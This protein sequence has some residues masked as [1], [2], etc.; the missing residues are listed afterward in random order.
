MLQFPHGTCSL[1]L[2]HQSTGLL[3]QVDQAFRINMCTCPS[4]ESFKN[5]V[6]KKMVFVCRVIE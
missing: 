2:K 5:N 3:I 4:E 6:Y 1:V